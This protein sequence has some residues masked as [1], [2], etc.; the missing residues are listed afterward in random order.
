MGAQMSRYIIAPYE[1]VI[2]QAQAEAKKDD[3]Q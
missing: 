2:A 3:G 1:K